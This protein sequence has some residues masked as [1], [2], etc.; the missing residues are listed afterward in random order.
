MTREERREVRHTIRKIWAVSMF[1]TVAI[2]A[3]VRR[4]QFAELEWWWVPIVSVIT[5]AA[6]FWFAIRFFW[7]TPR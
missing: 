3:V 1:L 2:A 7:G 5:N 4:Q 6:C